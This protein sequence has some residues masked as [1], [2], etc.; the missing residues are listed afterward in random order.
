V[1]SKRIIV[2]EDDA[3]LGWLVQLHLQEAG[4]QVTLATDGATGLSVFLDDGADLLLLD[5]NLPVMDGLQVLLKV[6]EVSSVPVV[7]MTA[8]AWDRDDLRGLG[9]GT[10][11]YLPKPFSTR[12]LLA[13]VRWFLGEETFIPSSHASYA[14]LQP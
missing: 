8:Y 7:L 9:L 10:D 5:V 3:D 1:E 14:G 13:R 4:Y 6:R 11:H 12:D 2:V